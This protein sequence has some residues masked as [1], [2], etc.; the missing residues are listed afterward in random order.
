MGD[1]IYG[2]L[3]MRCERSGDAP[4]GRHSNCANY[5]LPAVEH[6]ELM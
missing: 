1:R 2:S 5:G 4:T 3:G 6:V